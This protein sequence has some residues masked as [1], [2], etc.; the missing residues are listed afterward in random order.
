[1]PKPKHTLQRLDALL[2][3]RGEVPS[4]DRARRLIMS[5][6][7]R[8]NR[9]IIDKP[10]KRVPY[11]AVITIQ[12][13]DIP[14]VSRGGL[15]LQKAIDYFGIDVTGKVAID[16]GASTGGFTDCLLQSGAVFVYAVDVGYG[17]LD[18]KLRRSKRVAVLERTNI[19]YVRPEQFQKEIDLATIDVSFISLDKVVPV[20][21]SLLRI[22]GQIIALIKP[23]FE[24]GRRNVGKGGVVKNPDIHR[25]VIQNTYHL[26]A[27]AGLTVRE[28]TYSPIKGPAGNI[29]YL[30]WLQKGN[31]RE[32]RAKGKELRAG[33]SSK[34]YAPSS[35][36]IDEVVSEAYATF[37]N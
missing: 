12:Q 26:A 17:Q 29:E 15:K 2:V 19:R 30:I 14:Y 5:G 4:R 24:A 32:L 22:G 3:Q 34:P 21:A 7:I 28:L 27:R 33:E 35:M 16:V 20:V 23:Q 9:Q 18:W 8:V 13:T 6:G 11:D 37:T 10:G 31:D 1:M 36:L 25:Q